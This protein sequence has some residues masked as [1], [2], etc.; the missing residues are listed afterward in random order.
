MT[1]SVNFWGS[2]PGTN[3]DC[4][5][6]EDYTTYEEANAVFVAPVHKFAPH[7]STS[8]VAFVELDGP[9][10]HFERPN[11]D[12]VPSTVDNADWHREM[13]VEAG[14]LHGVAAYNDYF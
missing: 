6:G 8:D 14:M 11:P 13:Q 10:V 1:Y 3:D 12:F 5:M 4:Y 2:K 7:M 9:D